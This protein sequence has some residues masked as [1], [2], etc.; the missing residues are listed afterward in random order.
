MTGTAQPISS[1]IESKVGTTWGVTEDRPGESVARSDGEPPTVGD[2]D[3]PATEAG[4]GQS[5]EEWL[6]IGFESTILSGALSEPGHLS[7]RLPC[8]WT[9]PSL[10][11]S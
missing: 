6:S 9:V 5:A 4:T 3:G 8:R 7:S 11:F 2:D 10:F 1:R